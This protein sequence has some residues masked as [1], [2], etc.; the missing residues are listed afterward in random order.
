MRSQKLGKN[1]SNIEVVGISP[2]GFRLLVK[3][4]EFFLSYKD[5][6]WFKKASRA[7]IHDVRLRNGHYLHWNKL[8]VDLE[9]K[10]LT[11]K[12]K[13]SLVYR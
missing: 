4:R 12:S 11:N 2:S 10:S 3:A 8:D 9:L 7:Q 1:T 13:Y 5:F 6:P